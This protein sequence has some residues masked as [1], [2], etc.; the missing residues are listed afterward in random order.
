MPF[1]SVE[2][3]QII[4][5]KRPIRQIAISPIKTTTNVVVMV[6]TTSSI[7]VVLID[8]SGNIRVKNEL[9]LPD[10]SETNSDIDYSMPIHVEPSPYSLYQYLFITNNGYVSIRDADTGEVIFEAID[11]LPEGLTYELRWKSCG[12]G[13]SVS[14]LYIASPDSIQLWEIN[15]S[16][17]KKEKLVFFF[18]ERR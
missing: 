3:A 14:T 10:E 5:L 1:D 12:F 16:I 7:L 11:P 9:F 8:D 2:V 4:D 15:V 17:K 13:V 6:R 18:F